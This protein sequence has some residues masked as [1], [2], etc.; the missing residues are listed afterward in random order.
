MN[1]VANSAIVNSSS[2]AT[3][4]SSQIIGGDSAYRSRSRGWIKRLYA[5]DFLEIQV[6]GSGNQPPAWLE[7]ISKSIQKLLLLKENWDSYGGKPVTSSA[8]RAA[9]N[10]V[11]W[12]N[13][14]V[15]EPWIVPTSEG[16]LQ[17]EWHGRNHQNEAVDVEVEISSDGGTTVYCEPPTQGDWKELVK[18]L[19]RA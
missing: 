3:L 9:L 5:Y 13:S 15:L 12:M 4:L 8:V 14:Q 10:E 16:G 18:S 17:L 2:S 19:R 7:T 6:K 1:R 11:L